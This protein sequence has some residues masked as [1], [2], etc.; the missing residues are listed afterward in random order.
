MK[1]LAIAKSF[2]LEW[3]QPFLLKEFPEVYPRIAVG[4][5]SGSDVIGGDDI[6]SRDHNWGPQ[7][8]LFLSGADYD[9]FGKSISNTLNAAAPKTWQS[10]KVAGGGDLNVLVY[11]IPNWLKDTLGLTQ[12]NPMPEDWRR[13]SETYESNLYFL[14]HGALWAD[15]LGI[16][17]ALRSAVDHYPE[18][19]KI[20][21]IADECFKVW[22]FG[23]YNFIQRIAKR[24]DPLSI[25]VCLGEFT[26]AVMK[27]QLLLYGDYVPYWKWLAFVFRQLPTAGLYAQPLETLARSADIQEQIHL[28]KLICNTLHA[29]IMDLVIVTGK[30]AN[31]WLLPLLNDYY[32]LSN[33]LKHWKQ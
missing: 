4:R 5:F 27:I 23:E 1:G 26:S 30:D 32:E 16:M 9:N 29:Q 10:F 12:I 19:T 21:R 25:A 2:F 18:G 6:I 33:K 28:V 20:Q 11:A 17:T 14:K 15:G 3:G 7:F 31:D 8:S 22:H 13:L 24:Q